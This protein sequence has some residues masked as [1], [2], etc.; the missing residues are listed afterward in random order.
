MPIARAL[1]PVSAGREPMIDPDPQIAVDQPLPAQ[2][3]PHF[4]KV[5]NQK[6]DFNCQHVTGSTTLSTSRV[7][8]WAR[9]T[10]PQKGF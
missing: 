9:G 4:W 10:V 8:S 6:V 5:T 7:A 1:F 3:R 2:Q